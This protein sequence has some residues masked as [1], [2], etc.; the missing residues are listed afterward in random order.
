MFLESILKHIV[1]AFQAEYIERLRVAHASTSRRDGA[2]QEGVAFNARQTGPTMDFDNGR[3]LGDLER[4]YTHMHD[5]NYP[6]SI[7][8]A[9]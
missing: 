7:M 4:N 9:K 6:E 3:A 1:K 5:I 2:N 8:K